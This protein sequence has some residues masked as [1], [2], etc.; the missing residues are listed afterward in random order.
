MN[1]KRL[2]RL[3][4]QRTVFDV[5]R[6]L[7]S[8]AST[9]DAEVIH[10]AIG[11]AEQGRTRELFSVYRD[12]LLS[13]GH[14]QSEFSKRKLAVLNEPLTAMA[15]D[16]KNP[17]DKLAADRVMSLLEDCEDLIRGMTHLL[18]S[19]LYP[20]SV[21]EKVF[22]VRPDGM[23]TI[24]RLVPVP[25]TLLDYQDGS[26]K[27]RDGSD[28]ENLSK[29]V[30]PDPNRYIIHRGNLLTLP[31]CWG[32]PL[33][34]IL[35]WW[36]LSTSGR[37]WWSRFIEKYGTPFLVGKY[38]QNDNTSRDVLERAFSLACRLGGLVITRETD[39]EL[40]QA[41][42]SD[43]GDAFSRFHDTCDREISKIVVGQ[44]LSASADPTGLGSGVA[45]L[46]NEVRGDI[47]RWDALSLGSTLRKQLLAQLC[48]I[49]HIDGHVPLCQFGSIA[50]LDLA[51]STGGI[52][53]DLHNAGIEVD[54]TGLSDLSDTIGLPL[55]RIIS[56]AIGP[57]FTAPSFPGVPFS[58]AEASRRAAFDAPSSAASGDLARAF[59]GSHAEI[60]RIV[61]ESTS[62]HDCL[63]R[64]S[65]FCADLR[66][67][68]A[69]DVIEAA[70]RAYASKP[71]VR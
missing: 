35:F 53:V 17:Q 25:H 58:A 33:R 13:G 60:A 38:D 44:T 51:K 36:L 8:V 20:V 9:V 47:K 12:C 21:A 61:R 1:L 39:I 59:R 42:A 18:D 43:A 37:T 23:I 55:R 3:I 2:F 31:D 26:M 7:P 48:I 27:I 6:E 67:G 16:K 64:L 11:A 54:D 5:R 24:D 14:I 65:A 69:S 29:A 15:Y 22:R 30:I 62:P 56:A 63:S 49:N 41:S 46:Q 34:S 4:V 70:M 45:H 66:P 28:P 52:L 50:N 32:G 57:S 10:N 19:A 68:V 71:P 40:K